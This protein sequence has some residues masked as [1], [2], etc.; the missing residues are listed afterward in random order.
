MCYTNILLDCLFSHFNSS[1][2]NRIN[3]EITY[4]KQNQIRITF[5]KYGIIIIYTIYT[6]GLHAQ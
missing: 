4:K 6:K 5:K 3:A 2:F 1:D